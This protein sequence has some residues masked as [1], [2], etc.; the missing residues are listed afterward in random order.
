MS[1]SRDVDSLI[2]IFAIQHTLCTVVVQQSEVQII[3]ICVNIIII[4]IIIDQSNWSGPF[5]LV[6]MM[7]DYRSRGTWFDP[8]SGHPTGIFS[9]QVYFSSYYSTKSFYCMIRCPDSIH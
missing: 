8:L 4:G 1:Q 2:R 5:S 9:L 6:V 3:D 7:L